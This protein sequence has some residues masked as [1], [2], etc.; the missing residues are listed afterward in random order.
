MNDTPTAVPMRDHATQAWEDAWDA[1]PDGMHAYTRARQAGINALVF[2]HAARTN[3]AKVVGEQGNHDCLAKR[4]PDE[5]YF[6]I[7]ARDP[8]G[9]AI[10]DLWAQHRRVAGGDPEHCDQVNA[11]A[12]AMRAWRA[13]PTGFASNSAPEPIAYS[14]LDAVDRVR[15]ALQQVC[16]EIVPAKAYAESC[17]LE[18]GKLPSAVHIKLDMIHGY[19]REGLAALTALSVAA[20]QPAK[21]FSRFDP[22]GL[23]ES[24]PRSSADEAGKAG[25]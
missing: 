1:L 18:G 14:R 25:Q 22:P 9:P 11:I 15:R 16:D 23:W 13:G 5:P 4:A 20:L 3:G 12:G 10:V 19:A 8:D 6:V 7:L 17:G 21:G 24:E 2:A